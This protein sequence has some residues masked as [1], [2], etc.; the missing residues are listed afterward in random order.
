MR[1]LFRVLALAVLSACSSTMTMEGTRSDS[2]V[3]T[4]G[5]LTLTVADAPAQAGMMFIIGTVAGG[6][7]KV[8]ASSTR[9]GSVCATNIAAQADVASNKITLVVNYSERTAICTADIR[10]VTYRAEIGSLAPGLYD[11][12]VIHR[13]AGGAGE[14]VLTRSVTVD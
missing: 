12:T 7:G 6:H 8:I 13:N 14:T 11:V 5:Q 4:E 3:T 9:Y 2:L 10:A 1:T